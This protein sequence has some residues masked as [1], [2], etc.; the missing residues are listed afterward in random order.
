MT[1]VKRCELSDLPVDQCAC[2]THRPGLNPELD[3]RPEYKDRRH[4]PSRQ[5]GIGRPNQAIYH[6]HCS[7]CDRKWF[8]GD[9]IRKLVDSDTWVHAECVELD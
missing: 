8:P 6:G 2:R 7:S 4:L 5:S 9:L 1:T 3:Q